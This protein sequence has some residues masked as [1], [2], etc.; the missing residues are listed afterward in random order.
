M[1][2]RCKLPSRSLL[3][4]GIGAALFTLS[5]TALADTPS[6][7]LVDGSGQPV[8]GLHGMCL[9]IGK[10]HPQDKLS[11]CYLRATAPVRHHIE[12]LRRDEFGFMLP[13]ET[14]SE[15]ATRLALAATP[16]KAAAA[17]AP[18]Y[19]TQ[20][21][22][23]TTPIEFGVNHAGLSQRNRSALFNFINSLEQYR[24]VESIHIIGHTDLSGTRHYNQWLAGK[25]AE[26]VKIRLLSMGADPRS[27]S[28][29]AEVGGGRSVE[30]IVVVRVPAE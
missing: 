25:R 26:S 3:C 7:Y 18:R 11:D 24:G 5:V 13:P 2:K 14:P 23:F 21:V 30:V 9:Q 15:R 28:V 10:L 20:T 1:R 22:R 29:N 19:T 12:P 27:L 16:D 6:G 8:T 17:P 4:H